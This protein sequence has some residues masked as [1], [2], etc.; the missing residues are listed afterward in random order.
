ME[1]ILYHSPAG[2]IAVHDVFY[3]HGRQIASSGKEYYAHKTGYTARLLGRMLGAAGFKMMEI[4]EK[5]DVVELE[6]FAYL[7]D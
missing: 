3:G 1:S 7:K 6:V 4:A 5:K 2:P